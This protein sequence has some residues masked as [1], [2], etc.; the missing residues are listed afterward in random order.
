MFWGMIGLIAAAVIVV[1]ILE[2]TGEA[3]RIRQQENERQRK[4][5]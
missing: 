5:R 3:G 1:T 4:T 2:H